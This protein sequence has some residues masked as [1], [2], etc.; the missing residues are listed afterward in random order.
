MID[1]DERLESASRAIRS[2]VNK[3]P[4]RP[5]SEASRRHR[6]GRMASAVL[7]VAVGLTALAAGTLLTGTSDVAAGPSTEPAY[8][9]TFDLPGWTLVGV[10]E[11]PDGAGRSHTLFDRLDGSVPRRVMIE[12]GTAAQDR[13]ATLQSVQIEPTAN[14]MVNGKE[15]VFYE[16]AHVYG[17]AVAAG[18]EVAAEERAGLLGWSS[19]A[20]TWTDPGGQSVVFLFE[21]IGIDE[22]TGLLADHLTPMSRDDWQ[23]M[24]A[25]YEPPVTTTIV[26]N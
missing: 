17:E 15:A 3:V 21:G 24:V 2:Q 8:T 14:I 5:P 10:W 16:T 9:Y 11:A 20:A 1:L 23:T 26:D 6:R 7:G 22:A 12:T 13:F 4:M 19:L 18:D 25:S